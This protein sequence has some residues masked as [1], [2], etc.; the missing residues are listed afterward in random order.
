M[1]AECIPKRYHNGMTRQIAVR[2]PERL[3]D[4]VDE[5]VASGQAA[6][7]ASV[8]GRAL[9]RERRRIATDRDIAILIAEGDDPD[10]DALADYASRQ[11]MPELD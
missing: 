5:L 7:R 2:L 10:M 6:S 1:A 9:E 8:V 4:F 3:V 11:P